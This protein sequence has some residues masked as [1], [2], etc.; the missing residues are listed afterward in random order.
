MREFADFVGKLH[1][2]IRYGA[3]AGP[4]M[5]RLGRMSAAVRLSISQDTFHD[6]AKE[7]RAAINVARV[8]LKKPRARRKFFARRFRIRNSTG[9][10]HRNCRSCS[11]SSTRS[12]D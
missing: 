10:D 5:V 3:T 12:E 7:S 1:F 2:K 9:S 8:N 4:V 11:D 6:F